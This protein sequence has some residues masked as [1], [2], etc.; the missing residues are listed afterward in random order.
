M[1]IFEIIRFAIRGLIANGLRSALTT[2][3]ILI[4]V[5]SV[6]VLTAVGNGSSK[7]I[8]S[9]IEKLG[10]NTITVQRGGGGFG[11]SA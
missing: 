11:P 6:I 7:A 9:S 3:G 1:N 8:S 5:G 2:L 4:G 10:T